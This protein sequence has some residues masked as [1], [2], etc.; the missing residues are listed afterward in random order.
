MSNPDCMAP[1]DSALRMTRNTWN[2]RSTSA[3]ASPAA[4]TTASAGTRTS[5]NVTTE[6]RRVRST[7]CMRRHRDARRRR[8]HQHLRGPAVAV[9]AGDE[10]MARGAGRLH[11]ARLAAQHEVGPV[12]RRLDGRPPPVGPGHR[13]APRG[14]PLAGEQA[15]QDVGRGAVRAERRRHHVG[16]GQRSRR[17]VAAELVGHET[18]IDQARAADRPAPVLLAD[19]Q[20][21]PPQL[22]A[23]APVRRD[24]TRSRRG[25]AHGPRPA[26]PA[27]S[28]NGRSSPGRI[29]GRRSGSGALGPSM[30]AHVTLFDPFRRAAPGCVRRSCVHGVVVVGRRG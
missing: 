5:S 8:G 7:V 17:G 9:A 18:E 28:G 22:G 4:P 25:A 27:R 13:G 11:R 1:T 2:W 6:K 26:A 3:E 24:R 10:Q 14:D 30:R 29:P 23:A 20:R 16:R 19:Q 21:G 15:G 12:G